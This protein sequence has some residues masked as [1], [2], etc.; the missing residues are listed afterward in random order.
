MKKFFSILLLVLLIQPFVSYNA[1]ATTKFLD[2][3]DTHRAKNE[4]YY[5]AQGKIINGDLTG[6][7]KPDDKVTRGEAAAM[8]G[9]AL[10]LNGEKR[11][12]KFLDVGNQ[13][14]ASGYIQSAVNSNIISGYSDG[15][16]RPNKPVTRGE[17]AVLVSRAF[18]YETN[19]TIS[20]AANALKTRGIAQGKPNGSFAAEEEIVRSDFAVFLARAVN[21]KMRINPSV[22]L[23]HEYIVN[24]SALNVRKGP[25]TEYTR[26]GS[27]PSGT[28][29]NAAYEVGNWMYVK[30]S[31]V[32][33]FVSKSYLKNN[34]SE[35]I[36]KNKTIV[37]DPGHGGTDG[38]STEFGLIEKD[39]TLSVAKHLKGFLDK[40]P[41]N[42]VLT[43]ETDKSLSLKERV[44]IAK[45]NKADTFVSIHNNAFDKESANGTET[46]YYKTLSRNRSTE[47]ELLAT[48]IQKRLV[49]EWQL[50]DRGVKHGNFH[51]IRET[52]MPA[53]LVEL[54]FITN[55]KDHQKLKSDYWRK[56]AAEAI[57]KGI[58]DYYKHKGMDVSSYYAVK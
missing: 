28:N 58:L 25:S 54:G 21:Y 50:T 3:G 5:L 53:V 34:K 35:E 51:V 14:F 30:S 4:I 38:G 9:R 13:Y 6:R 41:F 11:K 12:T 19:G 40:S 22:S 36:S 16:F 8:I 43:R 42:V 49:E 44:D 46:Y 23:K 1:D 32:E 29:V 52:S 47:S 39:V 27:L 7:F 20:S 26:V 24:A 18:K 15:T 31:N 45:K 10:N 55:K 56:V 17:M 57:Y 37:I 48:F 2:V 33:G